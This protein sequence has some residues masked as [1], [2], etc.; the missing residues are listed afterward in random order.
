MK[1]ISRKRFEEVKKKEIP[2]CI[3]CNKFID[4]IKLVDSSK[5]GYC[6]ICCTT[7]ACI[8][9]KIA[10]ESGLVEVISN[11]N[12]KHKQTKHKEKLK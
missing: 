3:V 12:S 2:W 4:G 11:S 7:D 10:F 9:W 5:E 8:Y 6:I 1:L